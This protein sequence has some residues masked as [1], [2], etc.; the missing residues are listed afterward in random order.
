V[1]S[2]LARQLVA[3]DR[4]TGSSIKIVGIDN[5]SRPGSEVNRVAL[6]A[7]GVQ[8]IHADL[9]LSE[10]ISD[11]PEVDWVIDAAAQPSVLA[12]LDAGNSS[13][14][15]LSHNLVSSINILE[16]CKHNKAGL[17]LLS[18]SRVFSV[19]LLAS[20][21]VKSDGEAFHLDAGSALPD[22]VSEMG[23]SEKFS[24][25][26]PISLYGAT[27]LASECLAL[28]YGEAFRFPVW[29]NRCG[30]LAG[31]GQFGRAD[32]GVFA[33]WIHAYRQRRGLEYIGFGGGGLQVR[34]CLHP[35]DL[36][37]LLQR[38]FAYQ[39]PAEFRVF[40]VGGG[41]PNAVSLCQLT[42][43]CQQRFGPHNIFTNEK[44]RPYDIPWLVMNSGRAMNFWDW[45]PT[46][47]TNEIFEDIAQFAEAHEDWLD[48]SR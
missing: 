19:K 25:S 5:L 4:S 33:Y 16:Y 37:T 28:E 30:V 36:A 12:G 46:I 39:G 15:L 8:L 10:D 31:A 7:C 47:S 40:N 2:V 9:R 23:L 20:L 13:R 26:A 43:W 21:P 24:T 44:P 6:K 11:L 18:T 22:G 38:Q 17:I 41:V 1:G 45:R 29:I 48:V 27:K 14:R 42:K 35:N 32:Q 34:D 3:Q